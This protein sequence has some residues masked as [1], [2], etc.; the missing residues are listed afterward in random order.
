MENV[1]TP[2]QLPRRIEVMVT[3]VPIVRL[4]RSWL[5]LMILHHSIPILPRNGLRETIRQLLKDMELILTSLSGGNALS[6]AENGR[7]GLLIELRGM[8]VHIA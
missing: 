5:D 3:G 4:I 2:G 1:V 8:D 7:L 6:A